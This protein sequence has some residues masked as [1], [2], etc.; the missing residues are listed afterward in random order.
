MYQANF[1]NLHVFIRRIEK[2][3]R[4]RRLVRIREP[5]RTTPDLPRPNAAL[6]AVQRAQQEVGRDGRPPRAHPQSDLADAEQ[7]NAGPSATCPTGA[8]ASAAAS[9]GRFWR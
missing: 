7:Y 6:R 1:L 3:T 5:K 2:R 8:G 4:S 9:A